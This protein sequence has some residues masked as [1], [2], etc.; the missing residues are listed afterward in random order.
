LSR[1][2]EQTGGRLLYAV[3]GD[4]PDIAKKIGLELPNRYVLGLHREPAE[5]REIPS[6][7]DQGESTAG[8]ALVTGPLAVGVY[9]SLGVKCSGVY[10]VRAGRASTMV[11]TRRHIVADISDTLDIKIA[12]TDRVLVIL[13]KNSLGSAWVENEAKKAMA[14]ERKKRGVILMPLQVDDSIRDTDM[15]W[16]AQLR[17]TISRLRPAQRE[18]AILKAIREA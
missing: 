10:G 16:M 13:S 17:E 8:V 7:T 12:A 11:R 14:E 9:R 18:E 2:S 3:A 15:L 1:I 5:R 6:D 4:L